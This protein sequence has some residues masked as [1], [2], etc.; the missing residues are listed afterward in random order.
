MRDPTVLG[1]YQVPLIFVG[2][3]QIKLPEFR[4]PDYY[5]I[6]I[7]AY[8]YIH[9]MV[10]DIKFLNSNPLKVGALFQ[11]TDGR[12]S[13]ES[14]LSDVFC[15]YMATILVPMLWFRLHYRASNVDAGHRLA[16][17]PW[18]QRSLYKH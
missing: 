1:P 8:T 6:Y 4:T 12:L 18:S 15:F 11:E 16:S 17:V 14:Y 9:V 5:C 13:C 3:S 7:H 2:S 10:I